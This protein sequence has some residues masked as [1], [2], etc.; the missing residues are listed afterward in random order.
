[1]TYCRT[2]VL[3][4]FLFASSSLRR[5]EQRAKCAALTA[6]EGPYYLITRLQTAFII[7]TK[8]LSSVS[9]GRTFPR[10][11]AAWLLVWVLYLSGAVFVVL[12]IKSLIVATGLGTSVAVNA[13]YI[14][15]DVVGL[16]AR[17]R[18]AVTWG[19]VLP[20]DR[21]LLGAATPSDSASRG[22]T[23]AAWFLL[24]T[25]LAYSSTLNMEAVCPSES[26]WIS[27]VLHGIISQKTVLFSTLKVRWETKKRRKCNGRK[28]EFCL[29]LVSV[30]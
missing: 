8:W 25:F 27:T 5:R 17:L 21:S 4:L 18:P 28:R 14:L 16:D 20:E 6:R 11:A 7:M 13:T 19:L 24:A 26:R 12:E 22:Q 1:M 30:E 23:I 10:C 2:R 15:H 29:P 9:A 3:V